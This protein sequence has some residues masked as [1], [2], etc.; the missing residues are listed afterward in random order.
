MASRSSTSRE[1]PENVVVGWVRRP[2]GV[3]G[4]VLVEVLS[5]VPGRLEA[6]SRLLATSAAGRS[7][8]TVAASRRHQGAA[9]VSF[10]EIADRTAAEPLRGATLEVERSRVPPA[11]LGSFYHWQLMGCRVGDRQAGELGAVVDLIEDG[12]GLLLVVEGR[13]GTVPVP[14]VESYLLRVVVEEGRIELDLPPGLLE[15]CKEP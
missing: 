13:Q 11:P 6:G 7:S 12:G 15:I 2:H 3:K 5:D 1:L 8:L 4:E 10:A 14:F 9:L